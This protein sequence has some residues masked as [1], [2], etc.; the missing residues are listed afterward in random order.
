VRVE[1]P[2]IVT[3]RRLL[4]GAA[5]IVAGGAVDA[6]V[7][8]PN[9]LDV[10]THDVRVP[11]L[12][13]SLEGFAIAQVTDAHLQSIGRVE[14]AIVQALRSFDIQLLAMTG[15]IIDSAESLPVLRA[16][17]NEVRTPGMRVIATLGN[18]EHWGRVP[19]SDLLAAYSNAGAK[20]LV[21]ETLTLSDGLQ[22]IATDDSTGGDPHLGVLAKATGDTTLFLTHSPELLDRIPAGDRSFALSLAGHT[23]GGQ[24]RLG[25]SAVP[26][27]PGGSGRFVAGWYDCAAG[28]AYVSR[29]TGTS[30][31]PVRFTCRPELPIFRLRRA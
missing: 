1:Q 3:R 27:V 14:A 16:F 19:D 15:D 13:R 5:A 12:P 4:G 21:N 24:V 2:S 11:E 7:I 23:H 28:Q 10:T 25:A 9:W 26:F 30:I 17:C 8:E 18:W 6:F 31:A 22:V 29:G 20:L